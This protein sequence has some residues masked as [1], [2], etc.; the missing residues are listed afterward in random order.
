VARQGGGA[1]MLSERFIANCLIGLGI[2]A[3]LR[4]FAV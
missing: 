4:G 1:G 3:M 2:V